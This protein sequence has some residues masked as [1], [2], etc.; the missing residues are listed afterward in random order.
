MLKCEFSCSADEALPK[1]G[2]LMLRI[3][4]V[5]ITNTEFEETIEDVLDKISALNKP[6]DGIICKYD[7]ED[8][9]SSYVEY[10]IKTIFKDKAEYV[11]YAGVKH[12]PTSTEKDKL[13]INIKKSD[14][15]KIFRSDTKNYQQALY[16]K[17]AR[18]S[19]YKLAD[20]EKLLELTSDFFIQ[21]Y[22]QEGYNK[23]DPTWYNLPIGVRV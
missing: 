20:A 1:D 18:Y 9:Y 22:E 8:C 17:F 6:T 5:G 10:F 19:G 4:F 14:V 16:R 2:Y 13:F 21:W 7:L 11:T 12:Y 23:L 15:D 3:P